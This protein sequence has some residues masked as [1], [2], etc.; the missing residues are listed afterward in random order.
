MTCP[1]ALA[2]LLA[3]A[4]L[5][6]C[7]V[8]VADVDVPQVCQRLPR[9]S[10]PV[11]ELPPGAPRNVAVEETFPF[12][13]GVELPSIQGVDPT[14]IFHRITLTAADPT[15]DFTFVDSASLT[16]LP[17]ADSGLASFRLDFARVDG[18]P[19]S[20]TAVTP[21][22][23]LNDYLRAGSLDFTLAMEGLVP[24]SDV[25]FTVEACL[26]AQLHVEL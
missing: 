11:P 24:E 3:A 22:I 19:R 16:A 17:G 10:V 7:H 13:L 21:G 2:P 18:D 8:M 1:R 4:I 23:R 25:A 26:S 15:P 6:G 5:S 12:D 20:L 9:Q 14:L